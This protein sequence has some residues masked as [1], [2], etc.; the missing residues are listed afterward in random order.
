VQYFTDLVDK[1]ALITGA[2]SGIGLHFADTL[3]KAGAKVVLAA[4]RVERLKDAASQ[5]NAKG[6]TGSWVQ[7]DVTDR[8]SVRQ[9]FTQAERDWGSVDIVINNAGVGCG[10]RTLDL[11][12]LDC[13][14]VVETN[15]TGAW[16]VAQQSDPEMAKGNRGGSIINI[17]S[18]LGKRVM[19]NVAPYAAAKAALE[20]LTR[21][22][23][24][25][26]A[27]HNIRV[28]AIA[29][30]YI[31]T[32]INRDYLDSPAG[33]KAM[34]KIPQRKFGS[35]EDLD[36]AMLLLASD[37]SAYMT[38]TTIVVDGGHLQSSM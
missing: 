8:E 13:H 15:L 12:Q 5:I 23:A 25:E 36:G 32:D 19:G 7:M 1:T 10:G 14:D 31:V 6:G 18:I 30:G 24:F 33:E 21:V 27:R 38:G 26:W 16:Y 34:Q 35:V 2:S 20:H 3:A 17:A 9:A 4:R 29:P 11:S 22:L 28:N 37:A